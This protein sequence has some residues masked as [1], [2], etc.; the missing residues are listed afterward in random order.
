MQ[1]KNNYNI[2]WTRSDGV[3]G[4]GIFNGDIGTLIEVNKSNQKIKIRFEDKIATYTY[5]DIIDVDL[6]Y[7]STIHKSQGNEFEA[8]I[9]PMYNAPPQLLYRNLLYTAVTRAKKLLI[10]VGKPEIMERMVSNNKR[11]LRYSGLKEFL[12]KGIEKG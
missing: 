2:P 10:L 7:C 8:V 6:A 5:E 9:I 11:T 4:E 3:I 1:Y 12:L